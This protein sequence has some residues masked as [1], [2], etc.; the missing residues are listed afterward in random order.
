MQKLK[1]ISVSL[2]IMDKN[3]IVQQSGWFQLHCVALLFTSHIICNVLI[4]K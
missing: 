3:G 2:V 4:W 1:L